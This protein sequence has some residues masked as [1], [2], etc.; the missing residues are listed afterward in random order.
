ML[1]TR[2]IQELLYQYECV[3]IPHFGAFLTRPL[4]AKVS[5]GGNF[6]PPRKEVT[7]NQLLKTNDGILAHYVA[8]KEGLTYENALRLIEKEV[9]SWKKRLKTQTLRFPGVGEILLNFDKKITFIPWGKVNFDTSSFGLTHFKRKLSNNTIIQPK[10]SSLMKNNND[11]LMF[12]PEKEKTKK[13]PMLRYAA[14]GIIGIALL[15]SS[16]YFGDQYVTEQRLV[17]QQKA[18]QQIEK[19]VQE[20]TFDLGTL[21]EI[22]VSVV[23]KP[24]QEA[25]PLDEN[26]YSVIAGSFRSIENAEKKVETLNEE[27]Y[28]AA[29]A[30]S[31]P[32]GL[33]RAAYGR[34]TSKKEAI[35]LLYYIKYTLKEDAWYLEEK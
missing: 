27:G 1:L 11:D 10:I 33:Y 14:I 21:S 12:T 34:F 8:Q 26:Y 30:Q 13:S 32:D 16:Y 5:D 4:M 18:Q 24:V 15:A 25:T 31:S 22:E 35:N 9:S 29:L 28:T 23:S 7:F 6:Y 2:Y 20:A 17:A 3:T 19:N